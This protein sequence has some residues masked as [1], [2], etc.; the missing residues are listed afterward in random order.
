MPGDL[1]REIVLAI[2]VLSGKW[3]AYRNGKVF[4]GA[5]VRGRLF[6]CD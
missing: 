5:H 3:S 2:K 6:E 4:F 1:V